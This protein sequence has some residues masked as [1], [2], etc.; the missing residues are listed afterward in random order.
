MVV[1]ALG[2]C[3]TDGD[4]P[5]PDPS[6]V[7]Q[8]ESATISASS[9]THLTIHFVGSPDPGSEPCGVDYTARAVESADAVSVTVTAH[10]HGG[11]G[12]CAAIGASRTASV[13]LSR[14][15]ADRE[16]IDARQRVP[17]PVTTAG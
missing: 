15:L 6:S 14:P 5:Y 9:S 11:G 12:G 16:V 2:G 4:S 7:V 17:V 1:A 8:A 3:G 10:P 13:E